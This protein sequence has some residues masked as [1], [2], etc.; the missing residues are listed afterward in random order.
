MWKKRITARVLDFL[1]Y[2][3]RHLFYMP[4][5]TADNGNPWSSPP[6]VGSVV[7]VVL[8]LIAKVAIEYRDLMK[9]EEE[10]MAE[11]NATAVE[12][13]SSRLVE[14]RVRAAVALFH[15]VC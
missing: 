1:F 13:S 4:D 3:T 14:L 10:E 15:L 5:D 7:M 9:K 6:V 2:L 8:L 11:H 12:P